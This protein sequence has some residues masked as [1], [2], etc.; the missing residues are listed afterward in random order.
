MNTNPYKKYKE[1]SIMT[2]TPEEMLIILYD[3]LLK[4][5]KAS[6]IF[7]EKKE[8]DKFEENITRSEEIIDYFKKTLDFNF[9]I[10]NELYS[11]YNFFIVQINRAKAS[12]N[13]EHIEPLY[14]LIKELRDAFAQASKAKE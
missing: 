9:P 7:L 8:Y 6:E 5:V 2:M 4:R 10:S 11:M 3:E 1:E 13:K 14:P 12:R